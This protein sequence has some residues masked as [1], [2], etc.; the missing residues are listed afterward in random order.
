MAGQAEETLAR[1]LS[2]VLGLR[3]G[4]DDCLARPFDTS[5]LL[6]RAEACL[7][8]EEACAPAGSAT[9]FGG[10]EVADRRSPIRREAVYSRATRTPARE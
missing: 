10:I 1:A 9:R 6:A 7:R 5:E 4:A 2:G 8:R 3:F